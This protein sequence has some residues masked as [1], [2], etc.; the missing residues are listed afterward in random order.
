MYQGA[1][2]RADTRTRE[3][4]TGVTAIWRAAAPRRFGGPTQPQ[5]RLCPGSARRCHRLRLPGGGR[6]V[7]HHRR[8]NNAC[9]LRRMRQ[10]DGPMRGSPVARYRTG[11]DVFVHGAAK[12]LGCICPRD[13]NATVAQAVIRL[14][15]AHARRRWLALRPVFSAW[16]RTGG[17]VPGTACQ[18]RR[19]AHDVAR[20]CVLLHVRRICHA[21]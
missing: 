5:P 14:L 18:N 9:M 10:A 11:E 19:R 20:R 12:G 8:T 2:T 4:M 21:P 16:R 3:P 15:H 6:W 17:Q 1:E 13:R 7:A